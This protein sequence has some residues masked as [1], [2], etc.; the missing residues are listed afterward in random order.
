MDTCMCSTGWEF[1]GGGAPD[2]LFA[3]ASMGCMYVCMNM[4]GAHYDVMC[5]NV[6]LTSH[7]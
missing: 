2:D 1:G 5:I 4:V 7:T 6:Q 3:A